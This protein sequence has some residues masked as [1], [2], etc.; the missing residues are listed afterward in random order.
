MFRAAKVQLQRRSWETK[1][2]NERDA[3]TKQQRNFQQLPAEITGRVKGLQKVGKQNEGTVKEKSEG[4]KTSSIWVYKLPWIRN[5]VM[6]G[7]QWTGFDSSR[8]KSWSC[9]NTC[10][11]HRQLAKYSLAFWKGVQ[12]EKTVQGSYY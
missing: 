1:W 3:V 8:D 2:A 6:L 11:L 5:A 10:A 12:D 4:C 7:E 9:G